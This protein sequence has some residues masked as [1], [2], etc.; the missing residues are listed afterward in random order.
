[1]GSRRFRRAR[2][3]DGSE[4]GTRAVRAWLRCLLGAFAVATLG[5]ICCLEVCALLPVAFGWRAEAV[6]SGSMTPE[7]RPGDIV[8][9]SAVPPAAI[10]TGEVIA[11]HDPAMPRTLVHRVWA[12][13]PD[14]ELRTKGDANPSPDS[15]PVPRREV[16]GVARLRVPWVALPMYWARTHQYDWLAVAACVLVALLALAAGTVLDRE[17]PALAGTTALSGRELPQVHAARAPAHSPA[18]LDKRSWRGY[19]RHQWRHLAVRR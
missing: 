19:P 7:V 2:E 17:K 9:V 13:L 1:M 18:N 3:R 11:F 5:M 14:G 15:D 6:L 16:I 12:V 4:V 10:R 8:L